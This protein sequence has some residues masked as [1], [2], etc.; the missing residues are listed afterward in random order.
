MLRRNRT[1]AALALL[2]FAPVVHAEDE[3]TR[4]AREELERQLRDEVH[5]PPPS[6]EIRF[7]GLSADGYTLEDSN[8][9]LDG[10]PLPSPLNPGPV[11][12]RSS[13][14]YFGIVSP[15]DHQLE[16]ELIFRSAPQVGLFSYADERRYKVPGRFVLTAE[17]G[18]VVR[19]DLMIEVDEHS[20][21]AKKR[22][23]L[24]GSMQPRMV[25][26]ID[27]APL[28]EPRATAA[29]AITAPAI[30][31]PAP[32]GRPFT[33]MHTGVWK[34]GGALANLASQAAE[35]EPLVPAG[36][37]VSANVP[38]LHPAGSKKVRKTAAALKSALR[39]AAAGAA[40]A[41]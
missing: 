30:I 6:L 29:A 14:V 34:K 4:K 32:D 37:K 9:T 12:R 40:G 11:E 26:A 31:G 17:R 27:D 36:P 8:F 7:D 1:F 24:Q 16:V 25:A 3:V 5:L 15:G 23:R 2:C 18:L 35:L 41:N 39:R 20:A 22:L 21:D 19:V 33:H 38:R 28:P 10:A 13:I